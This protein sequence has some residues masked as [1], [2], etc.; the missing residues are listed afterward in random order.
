MPEYMLLGYTERE[1]KNWENSRN[2]VL[3]D[4]A[5]QLRHFIQEAVKGSSHG[6]KLYFGKIPQKLAERIK[7]N[8]GVAVNHFNVTLRADEILKI[9]RAHGTEA[10]EGPRG[11]RSIKLRDFE[12]I[13]EIIQNFDNIKLSTKLFEGKS[14]L[15]FEKELHG[16]TTIVS[17]VSTRHMDLTIQ[18][19]YS[20]KERGLSPQPTDENPLS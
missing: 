12:D 8:T 9:L 17:Y 4:S 18:T 6:K 7:L 20:G 16:R 5:K 15:L 3:Y 19:M 13:P 10:T 14:V 11:Q 1:R 2:I